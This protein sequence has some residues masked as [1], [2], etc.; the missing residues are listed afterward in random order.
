MLL[1][2]GLIGKIL[3][4]TRPRGA[5][6]EGDEAESARRNGQA[7]SFRQKQMHDAQIPPGRYERLFVIAFS[8]TLRPVANAPDDGAQQCPMLERLSAGSSAS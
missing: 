6:Y 1:E 3:E 5:R 8:K 4:R 2:T 7:K